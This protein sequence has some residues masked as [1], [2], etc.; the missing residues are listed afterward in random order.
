MREEENYQYGI[1]GKE[2]SLQTSEKL[3]DGVMVQQL[4]Q[5]I[6]YIIKYIRFKN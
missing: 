3:Q 6:K 5:S 2:T 4:S 1:A